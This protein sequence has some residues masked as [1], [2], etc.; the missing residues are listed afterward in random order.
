MTLAAIA[1]GT[2]CMVQ[3]IKVGKLNR[4]FKIFKDEARNKDYKKSTILGGIICG[5]FM[6]IATT[7]QQMGLMYTSAG[8]GG[9]ITA[10]YI[11]LV[12][13]IAAVVF[14][15]KIQMRVWIAV[16]I[17]VVGMYL[18]CVTPGEGFELNKGDVLLIVCALFFSLQILFADIYVPRA[19]PVKIA[20][21]EFIVIALG[22]WILAFA[23][24]EPSIAQIKAAIIPI[25]YCG[26]ISGAA[27][28][29]L[30]LI[31]QKYTEPT[32]ASLMMSF[33]SVFAVVGGVILLGDVMPLRE[34]LGCIIMFA[35]IIL[36][37]LPSKK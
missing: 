2:V 13:L 8:K 31:G 7:V 19:N 30:Q 5:L 37:Q 32:P 25:L 20:A 4:D 1:V 36:V 14:K 27:G 17:A 18:L 15:Q 12:P 3:D 11:L 16:L 24:E 21:I 23:L 29:T 35:A 34:L 9:F 26:L 22:S 33:E 10:L 6:G 28:Y